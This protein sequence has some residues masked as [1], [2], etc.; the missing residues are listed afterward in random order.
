MNHTACL[1]DGRIQREVC[2]PKGVWKQL[3]MVLELEI[4]L[5]LDETIRG[6]DLVICQ[7]QAISRSSRDRKYSRV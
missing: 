5:Q 6:G 4:H 1:K 7:V 3:E 2:L